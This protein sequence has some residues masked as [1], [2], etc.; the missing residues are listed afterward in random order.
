MRPLPKDWKE[1]DLGNR[2]YFRRIGGGTPSRP[3]KEFWNGSIPWLSNIE[4]REGVLNRVVATKEKVTKLALEMSQ[5]ELVPENS[6]LLTCTA[7]IGKVGINMIPL[8]TNQQFN[9]FVCSSEVVPEYLAYFLL[10]SHDRLGAIAGRTSFPHITIRSLSRFKILLP[11]LSVQRRIAVFLGRTDSLRFRREQAN[12]MTNGIIQSVFL[13]MFGD[14]IENEK[15]WETKKLQAIANISRGKFS[16]RPRNDPRYF[17]GDHPFIQTGDISSSNHRLYNY[18]QTL[19]ELGIK[20][21]RK[22]KKET[23]VVAIVGATIGETAILKIDTYATDSVVGIVP[24]AKY[25]NSEYLEMVLRFWKPIFRIQA[26][27]AARANINNQTL[28]STKIPVP[29][30]ELQDKFASIVKKI[31]QVVKYQEQ[32]TWEINELFHSAKDRAFRGELPAVKLNN[33]KLKA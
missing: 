32:S 13:K 22:F 31:D 12:Q 14:P 5:A 30:I 20:M 21:S 26:P 19:N 28:K 11:P 6:V 33:V 7:T 23:V 3:K 29:P 8:C 9:S 17:G 2:E 15:G 18:A 4:L 24:D 1:V 25:L 10:A 27:E 16:P